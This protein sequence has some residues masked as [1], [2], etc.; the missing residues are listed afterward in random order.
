LFQK[1]NLFGEILLMHLI[2][3]FENTYKN[4]FRSPIVV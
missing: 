2:F 3:V 1:Q 4:S